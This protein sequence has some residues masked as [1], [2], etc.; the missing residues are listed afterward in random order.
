MTSIPCTT[1]QTTWVGIDIAK[2]YNDVLVDR[3]GRRR[4]RFQVA[5][6]LEDY[7]RFAH[8]LEEIPER[9]V[10]GFE[11]TGNYHRTLAFFLA[12]KGFA[13]RL[14]SSVAAARTREALY[15]SWDKNDPKD[16]QVIIHMLKTGVTQLYHDPL[17]HGIN[18]LQELS[19]THFQISLH[20]V[21]I[22]HS[23]LTHYLPL[24]FP[25][26]EKYM[27]NTRAQW[28]THLLERYPCRAAVAK[29]SREDFIEDA[30]AY[31]G[32][33]VSKTAFLDDFYATATQTIGLPVPEHSEAIRMFRVVLR[34][35]Q[36][37][38]EVRTDIERKAESFLG[39]NEDYVRLKTLP[40]VG[41]ILSLTI[42][43][44]AGDLRRFPHHRQFLKFCGFD[45][46]SQQ[47]GQFRGNKKLSKRGNR[48]LRYAFW[49]AATVA[50]RMRE[51]SFRDKYT[52]YVESDPANAD[53]KRKAYTAVA[54]KMAR[55]AHGMIK[56]GTD[57]RP[58]H[59]RAVPGG[60]IPS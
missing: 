35:H 1:P 26:A 31:V 37:L 56:N 58:F 9:P 13:L 32:R 33:K 25:E 45:L 12:E 2:K 7:H 54:A 28:F 59:E 22:Q 20:K 47:S 42:L 14:V 53:L 3:P 4:R 19:R 27:T 60:I 55:V 49:M 8:F 23:I 11:A 41:P 16:A 5:N 50:I 44:E 43:A 15:N 51:N 17:I 40:G 52:R 39:T 36:R 21:R 6:Q 24:Y 57:Y 30:W 10:I 46:S 48:R 29:F 34:E 38:C 18:E